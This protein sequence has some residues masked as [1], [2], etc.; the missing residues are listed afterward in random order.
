MPLPNLGFGPAMKMGF[1]RQFQQQSVDEFKVE[2][3]ALLAQLGIHTAVLVLTPDARK[4]THLGPR[5]S[6]EIFNK[7]KF[8][9]HSN[10]AL[11]S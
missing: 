3:A 8:T 2:I 11:P 7:L 10:R 4:S 9:Q 6:F 5:K 1:S